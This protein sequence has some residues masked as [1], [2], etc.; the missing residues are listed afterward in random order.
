[1]YKRGDIGDSEH[2]EE[3]EGIKA[4]EA[5]Y[6][7]DLGTIQLQIGESKL[8]DIYTR[9][10]KLFAKNYKP[11]LDGL[12]TD[13]NEVSELIHLIVDRIHVYTRKATKNDK[14]AG[15]KKE[16]QVIPYQV[17]IDLRLPQ[18]MMKRFA[19]QGKFEVKNA[20]L[21]RCRESNPGPQRQF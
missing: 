7:T 10:L 11:F 6:K 17:R 19:Q 21:W 18:D 20:E 14:I 3:M 9:T 12:M 2:D 5:E 1:M 15:R 8:S 16:D 4:K 13:K